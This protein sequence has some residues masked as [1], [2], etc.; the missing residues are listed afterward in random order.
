MAGNETHGTFD[1]ILAVAGDDLGSL[2][3]YLRK[4]VTSMHKQV[5]EI[6]WPTQKIVSY[7]VGPKKMTEHY[8]Y[9]AVFKTRV[10]LGFYYGTS[11][12]DPEG[13]L[14]GTG[15]NLRHIK[16]NDLSACKAKAVKDLV[17]A[18]IADRKAAC[19]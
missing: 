12:P 5:V 9:V 16:L 1:D 2:C 17:R 19:S 13:L 3:T 18:A 7:G 11:L 6:A 14:E 15:Q 10:N 8:V 4:L